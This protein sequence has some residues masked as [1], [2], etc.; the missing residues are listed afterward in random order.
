MSP[1]APVG[2]RV[3]SDGK[4]KDSKQSML[5]SFVSFAT[6]TLYSGWLHVLLA[7]FIGSFFSRVVLAILIAIVSTVLLP[8]KPILWYAEPSP[9]IH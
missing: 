1:P 5:S 9:T 7:L 4:T 6:L 3:W 2:V 8:P